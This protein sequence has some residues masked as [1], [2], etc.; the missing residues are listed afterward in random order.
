[1]RFLAASHSGEARA[2]GELMPADV[3]AAGFAADAAPRCDCVTPARA[4]ADVDRAGRFAPL[5][6]RGVAV[7]AAAGGSPGGVGGAAG[8]GAP[9]AAAAA[10]G[11][12]LSPGVVGRG[13]GPPPMEALDAVV[14]P[15]GAD[16]LLCTVG[17]TVITTSAA[18]ATRYGRQR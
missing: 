3:G 12:V 9:A 6:G 13:A 8:G 18:T 10:A 5:V 2:A 7:V 17:T 14:T 11:R 4:V 1:M 15:V 16:V